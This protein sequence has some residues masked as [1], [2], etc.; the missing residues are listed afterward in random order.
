M[1]GE[2]VTTLGELV[3]AESTLRK[4][5]AVRFDKDGGERLRYF[6]T[7]LSRLVSQETK[8]FFDRHK[9]LVDEY[10]IEREPT[11]AERARQG[12][13]KVK[14]VP[15]GTPVFAIFSKAYQELVAVPVTIPWGPVT[16]AMLEPYP[17]VSS[18]DMMA[19]GPLFELDAPAENEKTP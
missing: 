17:D 1:A 14:E 15:R 12:P 2:I 4:V 3:D 13:E 10:G 5:A 8:Q 16:T 6:V 11:G 18:A 7:K 19:L 9:A